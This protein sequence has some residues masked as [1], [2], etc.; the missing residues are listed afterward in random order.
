MD[1]IEPTPTGVRLR[2]HIQPR[3]SATELVGRHGAA[4]KLRVAAPPVDGAANEALVRWLAL[5]LRVPSSAVAV[6]AGAHGRAKT[7]RVDGVTVEEAVRR[8]ALE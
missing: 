3:A 1:P 4:L 7:V 2:L 8:L 6:T 5:R